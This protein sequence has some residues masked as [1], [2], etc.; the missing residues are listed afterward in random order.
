MPAGRRTRV[1]LLA[2]LC[3]AAEGRG[4]NLETRDLT[5][6]SLEQLS[7][8]IVTS[9]SRRQERL[10]DAP[11]SVFVIT[12]DDI[13]RAG[14]TS[15]PE[16]LRLAPTLDVARADANQ[17]A[18]S[19]RGFNDVLA[20]KMLVLIDGRTVYT[21]LFSGVFWEAQD[22]LMEDVERIE[23]ISGPGA[24]LWGAN[25]VNGV[26]NVIT[27]SA[28]DT[29][30]TLVSAGIGNTQGG[31]AAR[32]GGA[33]GRDGSYRVYAKY[34]D[35]AA[36]NLANGQDVRDASKRYQA[37]FRTD[38]A[39]GVDAFTLQGDA[40]HG[41]IDQ[42]PAPR[43]IDGGNVLGRWTRS[44]DADR[45]L[46]AQA[47]FD[48]TRRDHPQ[49]FHE[50]LSTLDAEVQYAFAPHPAH[51]VLVGAGLREAWDSVTN[52]A[53]Q[54][55]LPADRS[56]H[57]AHVFAQ[58]E[59][60]LASTVTLTLGAK[61]ETNVY[62]GSEVLPNARIAWRIA[63][64]RLLWAA[65]SRAV[66]A[67]SR[68]DRDF[69]VPGNPPFVIT[70]NDTFRSEIADVAEVGYRSQPNERLSY[71]LTVFHERYD[72]LRS[73]E[74]VPPNPTWGNL[75]EGRNTGVEGW[76]TV[77][78]APSWRIIAGGVAMHER[79]DL[80]PDSHDPGLGIPSLG[81]DPSAWW[82]VR[83]SL[84]VTARHELDVVLRHVGA[85]PNPA[86]PAYTTLDLRV[87][88]KVRPGLEL[89]VVGQNL[90]D[91]SHAE[92][93]VAGNRVEFGPSVFLKV[94]WQP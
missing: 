66:R 28:K 60:A 43:H 90:A 40:Y 31:A 48:F 57:W 17:Y 82:S 25:A 44:F 7:S 81:N 2:A 80:K 46:T 42:S 6:L 68:I 59:I 21:P 47:Y 16:A 52:S 84:D 4:A 20:N 18:I 49:S 62:T 91:G 63:H 65:L 79:L 32:H 53:S 29:Q 88:W 24:T 5:E 15:I 92:W 83:S 3:A 58:D 27:R 13:R 86:V 93:G 73:Y 23:V 76:A 75:A 36:S 10:A 77:R 71:S 1:L 69:Y 14:A 39:H 54:A 94:L 30:G 67:P 56:L 55:F 64:D 72:R 11:A 50:D 51:R 19:A 89:S 9:V 45:A 87:G 41:E 35:L 38:L 22:V 78:I 74:P 33:L 85:R 8:I 61:L 34:E 70:G 37:G 26:I 12:A